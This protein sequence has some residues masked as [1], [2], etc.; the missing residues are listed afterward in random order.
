[1]VESPALPEEFAWHTRGRGSQGRG[2]SGKDRSSRGYILPFRTQP[3]QTL[4]PEGGTEK[5]VRP[6]GTGKPGNQ[7]YQAR[8]WLQNI[9]ESRSGGSP[10]HRARPH[11]MKAWWA[12]GKGPRGREIGPRGQGGEAEI[13]RIGKGNKAQAGQRLNIFK[14]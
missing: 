1:V 5:G 2:H 13:M 12:Y 6:K 8:G 14:G 7:L 9:G 10:P 4:P 11:Q 3:K